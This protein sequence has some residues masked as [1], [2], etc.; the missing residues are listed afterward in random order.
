MSTATLPGGP[1]A[2]TGAAGRPRRRRGLPW[3]IAALAALTALGA[4]AA[5]TVWGPPPASDGDAAPRPEAT[6]HVERTTLERRETLD[7]TLGH[8]GA[9]AFFARSDGVLTRLPEV[10]AELSAGDRAWEVDGR[11][12]ILLRGDAPAHR[13]LEPGVRGEDVRRFEQALSELGYGGFTVDDEYTALTAAAVETWQRNTQG[14]EVTGTVDPARIWYTPGPVR[15]TSHEVAVGSNVAPGTALLDTAATERVVRIDLDVD[16]RD[17]VAGGDE[18]TVEMP[19]GGTVTGEVS[20]VGTVAETADDAPEGTPGG[21]E[22]K[23]T[24]EVLVRLP[25][26][27]E[28]FL[29]R[30]PVTVEV[31]GQSREDVLAVP[32]GALIALS[33]GGYGVSVVGADGTVSDVP[34]ETGWFSD[35]LVE[36]TGDGV[37]EG[38]E[39]VVPG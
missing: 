10:G 32:V 33:G 18:V 4:L 19:G 30:A 20:S 7:G 22:E 34:V 37:D 1:E 27:A 38:T 15:V 12:T 29:D 8:P 5:Y 11:P 14:M 28:G 35:G 9:G 17:L 21:E 13:T 31:R 39:V 23:A 26:D 3:L 24:V 36:V 2:E 16:D 6:A 25:D